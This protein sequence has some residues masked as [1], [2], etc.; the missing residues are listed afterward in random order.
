MSWFGMA[1]KE[2]LIKSSIQSSQNSS[3][4]GKNSNSNSNMMGAKNIAL[5]KKNKN[6]I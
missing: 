2:K 4:T 1:W 5:I 6:K 3:D